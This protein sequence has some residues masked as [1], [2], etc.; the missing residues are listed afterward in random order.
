[1]NRKEQQI[2]T[3][4]LLSPD[5]AL[6]IQVCI[7]MNRSLTSPARWSRCL[8]WSLPNNKKV[9][10]CLPL[11]LTLTGLAGFPAAWVVSGFFAAYLP[12][13]EI[14]SRHY[15]NRFDLSRILMNF[16]TIFVGTI[17]ANKSAVARHLHLFEVITHEN[18]QFSHADHHNCYNAGH[19]QLHQCTHPLLR[20][21]RWH[22][23]PALVA[24]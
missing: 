12:F 14:V 7:S 24:R 2:E 3:H 10:P 21:K 8:R 1:M 20:I 9:H 19:I 15:A 6:P 5:R 18:P 17:A 13:A 16:L 23:T 11:V 22:H 4:C